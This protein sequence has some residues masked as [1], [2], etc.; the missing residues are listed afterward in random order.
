[1]RT[2]KSDI[3]LK[4]FLA[5]VALLLAGIVVGLAYAFVAWLRRPP[6]ACEHELREVAEQYRQAYREETQEALRDH[7]YGAARQGDAPPAAADPGRND[8]PRAGRAHRAA[9]QP[10]PHAPTVPATRSLKAALAE[11]YEPKI[12]NLSTFSRT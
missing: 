1:M 8:H 11:C 3:L 12:A 7:I 5:L 10:P 6:E 9:A 4:V 2:G